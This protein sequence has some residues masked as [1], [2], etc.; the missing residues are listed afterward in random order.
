ML[1]RLHMIQFSREKTIPFVLLF[2][3]FSWYY[4][5]RLIITKAGYAFPAGSLE[6]LVLEAT[7]P[8]SIIVSAV[9]GSTVLSGVSK[10]KTLTGWVLAGVAASLWSAI[11]FGSA[12]V[13]ALSTTIVLG[14]SLG[15]GLPTCL[16][17]MRSCTP[18]GNRG[19]L[20]GIALF[21]A[22]VCVPFIYVLMSASS[23]WIA[24]LTLVGWRLFSLPFARLTSESADCLAET[25]GKRSSFRGVLRMRTFV[26]YFVAWLMFSLV[27][28]GSVV[29]AANVSQFG[30]LV[31]AVEPA[32][33]GVSTLIG[34]IV[35][36]WVGRK[37]V[38]IFGF[39]SLGVAY[40]VVGLFSSFPAAWILYFA[41]DGVAL[42]LLWVLFMIVLWGDMASE[43]SEKFYALGEIPFFLTEIISV[44][45]VSYVQ[46]IPEN[47]IFSLAAFFLFLAVL[48]L[49]FA[50]ETLPEKN[51]RDRELKIYIEQAKKMEQKYP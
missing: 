48:P 12:F 26:L 49:L 31:K 34:G 11:P 39:V 19:K 8:I 15:I 50:P 20:G 7:F 35:S 23:L 30:V 46:E 27:D 36:D 6:N 5:E 32:F 44:L 21:G 29:G 13:G 37:K 25:M 16:D 33:A 2:N 43:G 42:G 9:V 40:A 1:Q 47:N 41:V 45:L 24:A 4:L 38:L 22:L 18:I 28:F 3:T 51:I 17:Y 14:V 10:R